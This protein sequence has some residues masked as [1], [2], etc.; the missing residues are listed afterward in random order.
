MQKFALNSELT[1]CK[2]NASGFIELQCL[3]CLAQ[4]Q[5]D[6]WLIHVF[7][8]E[9]KFLCVNKCKTYLITIFNELNHTTGV[10]I[11]KSKWSMWFLKPQ[12]ECSFLAEKKS[13]IAMW[14]KSMVLDSTRAFVKKKH[15]SKGSQIFKT[16]PTFTLYMVRWVFVLTS[17]Y[18]TWCVHNLYHCLSKPNVINRLINVIN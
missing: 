9:F 14:R 18:F 17:F 16:E 8:N 5:W 2:L 12:I 11:W 10:L 1:R 15:I 7:L 3:D 13:K 6:N 4:K